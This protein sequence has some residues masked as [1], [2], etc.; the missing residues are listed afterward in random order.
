MRYKTE[1]QITVI[2][3]VIN[4]PIKNDFSILPLFSVVLWIKNIL[5]TD[6]KIGNSIK[7]QLIVALRR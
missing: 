1:H 5:K 4:N 7:F 6:K 2:D 3:I